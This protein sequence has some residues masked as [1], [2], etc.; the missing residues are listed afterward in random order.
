[1]TSLLFP[2]RSKAAI[3]ALASSVLALGGSAVLFGAESSNAS[4]HREAPLIA[5]DPQYDNTDVYAFVARTA[6]HRDP[7]RATGSRSR[8]RPAAR[9]STRSRR[10]ARYDI[11][12]DNNG[13]AKPDVDLPVDVQGP[14]TQTKDTFLYNT[15]PVTSLDDPNLNFHQ[16]YTLTKIRGRARPRSS[17]ATARSRRPTSATR[18]CRTTRRCATQ[19]ITGR[20]ARDIASRSPARPRTRSSSTCAS[21]TCSTAATCPRPATTP[22]PA[23]TST[24]SPCRCRERPRS[25]R[26]RRRTRSSAS[27]ARPSDAA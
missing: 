9:T 19:A 27:G 6:G 3:A 22:W 14:A 24:R 10:D 4:S 15:G 21:S 12:I 8:S 23:T 1:M 16:T 5:R 7:G 13:D 25:A 20:P 11:N 17:F 2:S 18:P 26:A